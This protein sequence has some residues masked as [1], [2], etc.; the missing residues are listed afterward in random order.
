MTGEDWRAPGVLLRILRE[1]AGLDLATLA[2][3]S[4]GESRAAFWV[5]DRSGTVS[6]L[7]IMPG[8]AGGLVTQLHA[9]EAMTTRLRAR[10]YPAPRITALGRTAGFAFWIEQRLPGLPL[11]LR[12]GFPDLG[13]LAA[14]LPEIIRLND[15]QAG[16]GTGASN[17]PALL[18]RT[19]TDG[20][21][22]YCVHATLAARPDTRDMLRVIREIGTSSGPAIPPGTDYMHYDFT[23]ANLLADGAAITGVIDMNAPVLAGDRAFDLATLLF[24]AYDHDGI[25]AGLGARLLELAGHEA[26]R[27][28]LAH[29]VLRQVDW[30]VRHYPQAPATRRHLRLARLVI[31]DI[32]GSKPRER[33]ELGLAVGGDRHLAEFGPVVL[34]NGE[35]DDPWR[36]REVRGQPLLSGLEVRGLHVRGPGVAIGEGFDQ[37]VLRGI[38][39]ASGPVEPQAAR[40]SAAC[41]GELPR[42]LRPG[43]GVL[44]QDPELG[45]DEDHEAPCPV[46]GAPSCRSAHPRH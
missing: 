9:L 4:V 5:T 39:H 42:D 24:Y 17:W 32:A 35:V 16:L 36:R 7:K 20:A 46:T 37:H 10:D 13:R 31:A 33:G 25:R 3:T 34:R 21:D 26:A 12:P 23:P 45:S 22:G 29:I 44:R 30:S 6:L 2:P 40:L 19:L 41:L 28:Y 43:V 18:I 15:A 38:V 1:E 8:S 14:L 27:A 11:D